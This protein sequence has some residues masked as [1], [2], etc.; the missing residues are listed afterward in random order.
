MLEGFVLT[1]QV[2]HGYIHKDSFD[3]PGY[4]DSGFERASSVFAV[5]QSG[6]AFD[7]VDKIEH[8]E[9]EGVIV[10][11]TKLL[12]GDILEAFFVIGFA[13]AVQREDL[14]LEVG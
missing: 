10:F 14:F 12:V 9:V 5:D 7:C 1:F 6:A 11:E 4:G 8:F 2:N 3:L 13:F